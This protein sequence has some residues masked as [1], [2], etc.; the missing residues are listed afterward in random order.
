MLDDVLG[1]HIYRRVFVS[2]AEPLRVRR[3]ISGDVFVLHMNHHF[4]DQQSFEALFGLGRT[5][6]P[7]IDVSYSLGPLAAAASGHIRVYP[8]VLWKQTTHSNAAD[9]D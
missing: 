4:N 9:D 1:N 6:T 3:S 7:S 5:N 2:R 8:F